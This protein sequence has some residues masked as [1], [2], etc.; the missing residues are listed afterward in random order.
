MA[1]TPAVGAGGSAVTSYVTLGWR[2]RL[3]VERKRRPRQLRLDLDHP[4]VRLP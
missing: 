1:A 3:L 4:G 2:A